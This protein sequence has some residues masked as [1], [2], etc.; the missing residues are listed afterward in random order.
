ME[1]SH[2]IFILYLF[3]LRIEKYKRKTEENFFF[4]STIYHEMNKR[5]L[6]KQS[7]LKTREQEKGETFWFTQC[8]VYICIRYRIEK[9]FYLIKYRPN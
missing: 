2:L 7:F 3:F 9:V 5:F 4:I 1:L 6:P 8:I